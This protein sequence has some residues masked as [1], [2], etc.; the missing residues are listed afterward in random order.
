MAGVIHIFSLKEY[1]VV[2]IASLILINV[3]S[4]FIWKTNPGLAFII[5]IQSF[6]LIGLAIV[7]RLFAGYSLKVREQKEALEKLNKQILRDKRESLD[8]LDS[9]GDGILSINGDGKIYLHNKSSVDLTLKC[10]N[11]IVPEIELWNLERRKGLFEEVF[12]K[13]LIV[14]L[15]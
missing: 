11:G 7:S 2:V 5:L 4:I 14:K 9:I 12:D 13:K 10:Q 6:S 8:L 1:V 3:G 15:N